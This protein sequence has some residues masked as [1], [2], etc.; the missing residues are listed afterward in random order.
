MTQPL[1]EVRGLNVR[2]RTPHGLLT[3]LQAVDLV[4]QQ[5][6]TV[7]LIGESGCGKTSLGKTLVGLNHADC[8]QIL[9]QGVDLAPLSRRQWKPYRGGIQMVFQDSLSALDPRQRVVNAI[10]LPLRLHSR[11][12]AAGRLARRSE[13]FTQVG[14]DETLAQRFPHQLSGGQRQRLNIARALATGPQLIVCD[15]PVSAL[16]VSLQAQIIDLLQD[17]QRRLGIAYLFISH[18]LAVVEQIATRIAV[19]YLG[20]IVEI[21]P[22][23]KLWT[24]AAHPYT[25]LLLDAI[26][27]PMPGMRRAAVAASAL[28]DAEPPSPYARPTGCSF[29][30]RC[31]HAAPTCRDQDP[32]L[33]SLSGDHAVACHFPVVWQKQS[34]SIRGLI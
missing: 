32:A 28:A 6:E 24:H 34:P 18:D 29:A 14:L 23:S 8:G 15:E 9:Y 19:M 20:R 3:A 26:P 22:K 27:R 17:L 5:G 10:D 33:S 7:A 12:D 11:L 21:L 30:N 16:D 25:R 2:Y 13:L 4:V 1:L 31:P